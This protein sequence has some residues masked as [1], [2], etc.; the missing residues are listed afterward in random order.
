M[1][2]IFIAEV[3]TQSPFGF[4]SEESWDN[5]F[6]LAAKHG[7]WIAIHTNPL[8]G[9][10]FELLDRA[11]RLT[12]K[13]ILAKGIHQRDTDVKMA[14]DC[15]ADMVLTVGRI[16]TSV[17]AHETIFEPLNIGQMFEPMYCYNNIRVMWNDRDLVTGK[18]KK[19][20]VTDIRSI[21]NGWLC[22]ASY[23]LHPQDIASRTDI[24]AF[25]I[26]TNLRVFVEEKEKLK[27]SL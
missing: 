1:N 2:P 16:C 15:G 19:E 21:Y 23:I 4:K 12:K 7:D 13:P 5:L 25:I 22:K 8:W 6:E 10:S 9:G 20:T 17:E 27:N 14:L 26:G 3:K 18:R 24:D 11:R